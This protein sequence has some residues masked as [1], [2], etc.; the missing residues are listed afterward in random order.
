MIALL[1]RWLKR[2]R[3][4]LSPGFSGE[5]ITDFQRKFPGRC[6][7][8]SYHRYGIS[9]GHTSGPCPEHECIES[10]RD[11]PVA[12]FKVGDRVLD[13]AFLCG[14][15]VVQVRDAGERD[16]PLCEFGSRYY[17]V[18]VDGKPEGY[19][20]GRQEWELKPLEQQINVL[21]S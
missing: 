11:A 21:P 9:H 14:A 16:N 6:M 4:F 20:W 13:P 19:M 2:A 10:R 1:R 7:I 3:Q 8:C 5:D 12:K 18:H 15:T 17:G